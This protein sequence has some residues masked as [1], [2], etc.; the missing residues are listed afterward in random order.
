[1]ALQHAGGSA[2]VLKQWRPK[3][4][5][6]ARP[7]GCEPPPRVAAWS[8]AAGSLSQDLQ[9][10]Y[11]EWQKNMEDLCHVFGIGDGEE[12]DRH[13]GRAQGYK[14]IE[15][16]DPAR[17]AKQELERS[18]SP[19][20]LGWIGLAT[21]AEKTR[22]AAERAYGGGRRWSDLSARL[23]GIYA[24]GRACVGGGGGEI[25]MLDFL[26]GRKA[27]P[28]QQGGG[29]QQGCSTQLAEVEP[30]AEQRQGQRSAA[31][32]QSPAEHREDSTEADAP[33]LAGGLVLYAGLAGVSVE[34]LAAA[35]AGVEA[36]I[37]AAEGQE[38]NKP[39][40]VDR[41]RRQV[42]RGD[43]RA[44]CRRS[45]KASRGMP[46]H[47]EQRS[48]PGEEPGAREEEDSY[49]QIPWR[50]SRRRSAA[51]R[52]FGRNSWSRASSSKRSSGG[53]SAQQRPAAVGLR[54]RGRPPPTEAKQRTFS[55]TTWRARPRAGLWTARR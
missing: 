47:S 29:E 11:R 19:E 21:W 34:K 55:S 42:G 52:A 3:A 23:A 31:R 27:A 18:F 43:S 35:R 12:A 28:E 33:P 22:R 46:R 32:E 48:R 36:K 53:D 7:I 2:K 44:F 51:D 39:A 8:W 54:G 24:F 4:F 1:M 37:G 15:V 30:A 25:P 13:K 40:A 9:Q 10:A 16:V 17:C 38:R 14:L 49:V 5:P 6:P 45:G 50:M 20:T 26:I 41:V